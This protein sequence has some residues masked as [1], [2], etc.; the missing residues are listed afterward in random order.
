LAAGYDNRGGAVELKYYW[1]VLA[2]RRNI[3]RNTFLIVAVI[4]L[5]SVAYS[6][7]GASYQGHAQ[8][9]VLVQPTGKATGQIYDV[10]QAAQQNSNNAVQETTKYAAT[11]EYFKLVNND[12]GGAP[13]NWKA[14]QAATKIYALTDSHD[15]LIQYDGS[16]QGKVEKTI[17]AETNQLVSYIPTFQKVSGLP[18]IRTDITD[19][20]TA[21]HVS[22]TTPLIQFLLRAALGLVAG[23]ILA[24]LFEYLD[25]SI[26][27]EGDVRHWMDLPTLAVI[28]GGQSTRRVRSA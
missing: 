22:L 23:I 27:D 26:Q 25:D 28:P 15:I 3:I 8:I 17:K 21:Q 4:G 1:R 18:T 24:Y 10:N 12:I 19:Q 13:N 5:L 14:I 2:R 11:T 6:Y 7:Y 16:S 9:N 20:P